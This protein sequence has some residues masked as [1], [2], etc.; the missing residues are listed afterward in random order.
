MPRPGKNLAVATSQRAVALRLLA[1]KREDIRARPNDVVLLNEVAWLMATCPMTSMRNGPEA[2]QLAQRAVALTGGR[3]PAVLGTL[4]A[5]PGRSRPIRR[6][7]SKPL[8]AR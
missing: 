8:A 2:V 7:P 1:K 4:A 3:E 6:G 5:A